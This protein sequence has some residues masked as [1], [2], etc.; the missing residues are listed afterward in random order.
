MTAPTPPAGTEPLIHVADLQLHS[1]EGPVLDRVSLT[2]ASGECVAVVGASGSGKTTLA[3]AVLGRLRP[4]IT[5]HGGRVQ[6]AGRPSLPEP[7]PELRGRIAAYVGQDAG[8]TL[9]PYRR[10]G[11][12]VRA[13]LGTRDGAAAEAL[14]QQVGLAPS[15]GARRPAELSGGQQQR[16][17]LAVALAR[18]P[19]LLVLDE[20]TSALD[21]VAA[22]EVR[23]ALARLRARGVALLWITHDLSCVDGLVDRMVVLHEGRIVEDGAVDRVTRSPESAAA[24]RLVAAARRDPPRPAP[25]PDEPA[26]PALRASGLRAVLGSRPVLHGVDLTVRAGR[27]LA[28]TGA[29]GSGKSTLAR[30][31]A[32]LHPPAGGAVSWDGRP[33]APHA[34]AR[35]AVD[36]AAVQLVPQSP[37]ETLHPAQSVATALSRP[38]R[39]LRGMREPAEI[40]AET[41][42]LLALVHLPAD[43]LR[44]L[45][46]ELSGGQRQR[47][48]IARALAAGPRMLLC[49]E[50]TSALDSV[51]QASVWELLDELRTRESLGLLVITHDASVVDRIADEVVVLA[52]GTLA[53]ADVRQRTSGRALTRG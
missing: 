33:L 19:R 8:T 13:A 48:A 26:A 52:E 22:A 4:G 17:A 30:C 11:K 27:C 45:P 39:L 46:G 10:L 16:G 25:G 2:V 41:A 53:P 40:E 29:S 35:P 21:P 20:P 34:R 6:V 49:D 18:S 38:L 14:L 37:A 28:V 36:R 1:A 31:L 44:R 15:L 42:R 12:T 24:R 9:N 50:V 43:H 7:H 47:V 51:A 23:A 3:L 32:G 5:Q